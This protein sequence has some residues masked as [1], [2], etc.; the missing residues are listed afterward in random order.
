MFLKIHF[1]HLDIFPK[2]WD[3]AASMNEHKERFN[4]D[5]SSIKT[6]SE[7][8]EST[9]ASRLHRAVSEAK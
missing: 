7:Q 3:A 6:I 4:Q 1:L 8:V 5:I 2:I 9:Y